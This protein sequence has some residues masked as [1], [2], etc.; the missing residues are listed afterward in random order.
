MSLKLFGSRPDAD[1]IV[2]DAMKEL[3]APARRL[4]GKRL[5]SLGGLVMLSGCNITDDK[6]VNA[7]LRKISSFN[8]DAQAFLFD[9]DKLALVTHEVAGRD[10]AEA[11]AQLSTLHDAAPT[12]FGSKGA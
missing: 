12:A 5:L 11:A 4:F 10:V 1:L 7:M 6:S 3:K 2:K 8:D 9:P